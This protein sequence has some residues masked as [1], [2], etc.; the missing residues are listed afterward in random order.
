M[1]RKL[2]VL[3]LLTVLTAVL[4]G[5][6]AA[7]AEAQGAACYQPARLYAGGSGRVAPYPALPNRLRSGPSMTSSVIGSI[8]AGA[9]FTVISGPVCASGVNW[10]QVNY[11]GRVGWTAEGSGY[12]Y[13]LEPLGTVPPPPACTL[14]NR[15]TVGGYGRVTPGLPNVLRD[16]PGTQRTGANSRVIG[17][18]PGGGVFQVLGGPQCGTDGRWWWQVNY[19]GVVGWTAEG[20]GAGTYWVEPYSGGAY[21]CPG[22]VASRLLPGGYGAV[23]SYP[24][25]PNTLRGSYS[26]SGSRIGQ[27]P[28]GGVFTV[29]QGPVCAEGTAWW[30]VN[31]AGVVGWTAEGQG[32]TYWL[33]PR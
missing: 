6:S 25:Y 30:L 24:P 27:I 23:T 31:Y 26:F 8:P 32:S 17:E 28:V 19:N 7:P 18:I 3:M 29:L 22:F 20:E 33:E 2:I 12:S 9:T 11:N 15:L 14:P 1:Q 10:W 13:Y 21:T 5:F 4:A 16:A